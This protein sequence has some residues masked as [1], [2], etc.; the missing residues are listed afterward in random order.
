MPFAD[1]QRSKLSDFLFSVCLLVNIQLC[2][3]SFAP[4]KLEKKKLYW[5]FSGAFL[6]WLSAYMIK[7]YTHMWKSCFVSYVSYHFCNIRHNPLLLHFFQ[8]KYLWFLL[9]NCN[10]KLLYCIYMKI[11][12]IVDYVNLWSVYVTFHVVELISEAI[13]VREALY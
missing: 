11:W 2:I 6:S 3:I 8:F 13:Y 10:V 4:E 7:E 5:R 1:R 9:K 12:R